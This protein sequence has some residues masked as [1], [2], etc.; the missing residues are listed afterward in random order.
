MPRRF[1]RLIAQSRR[2]NDLRVC[3][4]HRLCAF[5]LYEGAAR[6]HDAAIGIGE[7][8]L[9]FERRLAVGL[10]SHAMRW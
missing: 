10:M 4:D 1:G 6:H 8:A 9:R 5:G 7:V 2:K 3:I